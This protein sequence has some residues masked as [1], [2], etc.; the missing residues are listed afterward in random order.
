MQTRTR[1]HGDSNVSTNSLVLNDAF[2]NTL[3]IDLVMGFGNQFHIRSI[4]GTVGTTAY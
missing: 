4:N 1:L 2:R 3:D